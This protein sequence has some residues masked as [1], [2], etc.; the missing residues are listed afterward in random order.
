M[1]YSF[2]KQS[3]VQIVNYR[4]AIWLKSYKGEPIRNEIL[5]EE[6]R[7]YLWLNS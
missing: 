2:I 6:L 1:K 3:D 5:D 7:F 4:F